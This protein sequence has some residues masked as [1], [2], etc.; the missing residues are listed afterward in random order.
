MIVSIIIPYKIFDKQVEKCFKH[1]LGQS[2]NDFEIIAL[3]DKKTSELNHQ[4]IRIIKTGN[5]KP[6]AKRNLAIKEAQGEILAFVDSDAYP[7]K[8]W[9]LIALEYLKREEVGAV[10]GP[11]LTPPDSSIGRKVSGYIF[12]STIATGAFALRYKMRYKFRK[13]LPVKEMPSCNLLVRKEYALKINGFD[14]TL[15][16]GEDAK[17]CFQIRK[18]LNKRVLYIPEAVVYHV[19]RDLWRPHLRQVWNYGRDKA[20]VIKEDFSFDQL[21]YFIPLLFTI[22]LFFGITLSGLSPLIA[23]IFLPL[24]SLYLLII[25]LTSF[26]IDFKLSPLLF[27]G[28]FLTHL[29]YGSGF[30]YGL[31]K[32]RK[33][34]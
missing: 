13:G 5:L 2:Y 26:F 4:K 28:I 21:Y 1:C 18:Q 34:V 8:D 9:L 11:N 10:G 3:P 6:S 33:N 32:K 22:F 30:F 17:F 12:A 25:I 15:L 23:K 7:I 27:I 24:I 29:T 19:R 20:W 14:E 31:V 16:T